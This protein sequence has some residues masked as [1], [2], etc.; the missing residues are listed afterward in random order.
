[1]SNEKKRHEPRGVCLAV[2]RAR[3]ERAA[4]RDRPNAGG[5]GTR[6]FTS[7]S[8]LTR[9][10]ATMRAMRTRGDM[11]TQV[12]KGHRVIARERATRSTSTTRSGA[13]GQ[14]RELDDGGGATRVRRW[15]T[16]SMSTAWVVSIPLSIFDLRACS[17]P[18]WWAT[19]RDTRETGGAVSRTKSPR[20]KRTLCGAVLEG[21]AAATRGTRPASHSVYKPA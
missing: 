11:Q 10:G 17:H 7:S 15:T 8:T 16:T 20:L 1:M 4:G 6:S 5:R 21:H 18:H 3:L 13:E 9:E 12:P 14:M 19:W 2:V